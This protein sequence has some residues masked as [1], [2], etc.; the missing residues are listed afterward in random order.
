MVILMTCYSL[1]IDDLESEK[2]LNTLVLGSPYS[3]VGFA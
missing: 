2:L 1:G 3:A